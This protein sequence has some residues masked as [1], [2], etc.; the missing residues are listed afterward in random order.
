MTNEEALQNL[1][2]FKSFIKSKNSSSIFH[3]LNNIASGTSDEELLDK[4][5]NITQQ[6]LTTSSSNTTY[7]Q[8]EAV[9]VLAI[10]INKNPQKYAQSV[11]NDLFLTNSIFS[12]D[13]KYYLL[14][15][16]PNL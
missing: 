2:K 15:S 7:T 12:E 10:L 16:P 1:E 11:L 8:T 14:S 3:A 13:Q 9:H 6:A 5:L 4:V